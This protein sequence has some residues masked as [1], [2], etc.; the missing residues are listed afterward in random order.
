MTSESKKGRRDFE[1]YDDGV[2][3]CDIRLE[4]IGEHGVFQADS[5]CNACDGWCVKNSIILRKLRLIS[6]NIWNA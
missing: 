3:S 4:I 1:V 6:F 2:I 5:K